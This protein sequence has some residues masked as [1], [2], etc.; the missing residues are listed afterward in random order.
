M[1]HFF[2]TRGF[3]CSVTVT[4]ALF[5]TCRMN[6]EQDGGLPS[7]GNPRLC[8]AHLRTDAL[9][10]SEDRGQRTEDR[11]LASRVSMFWRKILMVA[12]DFPLLL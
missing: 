7:I 12:G 4:K 10:F 8:L 6:K 11:T 2:A 3:L 9:A 1:A 5:A